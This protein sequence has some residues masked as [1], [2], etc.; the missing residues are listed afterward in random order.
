MTLSD[1][2]PL[3]AAGAREEDAQYF[4]LPLANAMT[5][6]EIETPREIAAFLG[7]CIVESNAL[8]STSENLYYR[9]GAR[10]YEVWRSKFASVGEAATYAMRPEALANRV[11]AGR[12]GNG[13]VKSGDGWR[14]RGRGLIM[15]TGRAKYEDLAM[16]TSGDYLNDP[17]LVGQPEGAATSAAWFWH[18]NELG[19]LADNWSISSITRIVNGPAMLNANARL[20]A[21]I[22]I[23]QH[24][25]PTDPILKGAS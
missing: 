4:L 14:F 19:A 13:D 2:L 8:Q 1:T 3:V 16:A 10:I 23:L 11:Y 17:D 7:Q 24:L 22:I 25:N 15:I 21:S 18:E 5:R 12:N 20:N 6:F 9:S